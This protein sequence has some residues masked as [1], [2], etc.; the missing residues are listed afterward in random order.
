MHL[1]TESTSECVA[2]KRASQVEGSKLEVAWVVDTP[3]K[4]SF[5]TGVRCA[6]GV[7]NCVPS[8]GQFPAQLGLKG[9]TCVVMD[10]N[11]HGSRWGRFGVS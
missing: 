9:M 7:E 8:P 10:K 6:M 3:L 11:A 1:L 5:A 4:V 2:R